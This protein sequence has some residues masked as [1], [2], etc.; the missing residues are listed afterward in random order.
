MSRKVKPSLAAANLFTPVTNKRAPVAETPQ[1]LLRIEDLQTPV[2][3]KSGGSN[4]NSNDLNMQDDNIGAE[5]RVISPN[6]VSTDSSETLAEIKALLFTAIEKLSTLE[7]HSY[8]DAGTQTP[9]T[10][11]SNNSDKNKEDML[12]KE[13]EDDRIFHDYP[14]RAYQKQEY[15]STPK[16]L[17]PSIKPSI[18]RNRDSDEFNFRKISDSPDENNFI[19]E[20][21]KLSP[22][23]IDNEMKKYEMPPM[24]SN[25]RRIDSNSP[26]EGRDKRR[27]EMPD[28]RI[29]YKK[30]NSYH[31]TSSDDYADMKVST[32]GSR[33]SSSSNKYSLNGW[34]TD[35]DGADLKEK[36]H[37]MSI[38]LRN[39]EHQ[40]D[41]IN[42]K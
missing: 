22:S 30:K 1:V 29:D 11:K 38:V 14:R 18:N 4:K 12:I 15:I 42:K 10:E 33:K 39:L 17:R 31:S 19:E 41:T 20:Y 9:P 37:Q 40:L 27:Y 21:K 34:S 7:K 13:L 24:K 8:S 32:M 5:P 35:T 25:L 26:T 2:T 36:I 23:S 16:E 28:E 3:K 6:H